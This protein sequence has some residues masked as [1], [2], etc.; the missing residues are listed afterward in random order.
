MRSIKLGNVILEEGI[1]KI[2]VPL[3]GK[4]R[5]ELSLQAEMAAKCPAADVVEWRADHL[6][7]CVTEENVRYFIGEIRKVLGEKPLL[8]TFRSREEGGFGIYPDDLYCTLVSTASRCGVEAVDIELSRGETALKLT[9]VCHGYGTV[10]ISSFHEFHRTPSVRSMVSR[11]E[12]SCCSGADICKL[13]VMPDSIYDTLRLLE[14][15]AR[16]RSLHPEMPLITVSMGKT[17]MVSRMAGEAFGSCMTFGTISEQSAPGQIDAE[18][19]KQVL[20]IFH[21]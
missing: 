7:E 18:A 4:S 1:P 16:M 19:L 3:T 9:Q 6:P 10:V 8:V 2:C 17:G 14:A 20:R 13:A 11:L 5:E 21:G 15:T 12:K